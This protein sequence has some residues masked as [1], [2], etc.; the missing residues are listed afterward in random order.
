MFT[1]LL[2]DQRVYTCVHFVLIEGSI[3]IV[4]SLCKHTFAYCTYSSI[5]QAWRKRYF[6]L[7]SSKILEYYKSENGDLK[8][9][10]NLEDCKSVNSD[11]FH[12]KHKYVFD[13]QTHDRVY[14]LVAKSTEEMTEWVDALCNICGFTL[15]SISSNYVYIFL[16]CSPLH[17]LNLIG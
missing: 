9:V 7:R 1:S 12:K 16:L 2:V 6:Q 11:L 3:N 13:I 15:K 14:Y 10:I 4:H 17:I 5:I 8:G